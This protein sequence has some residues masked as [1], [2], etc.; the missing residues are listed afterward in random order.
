[1]DMVSVCY[2]RPV[3]CTSLCVFCVCVCVGLSQVI[4]KLPSPRM[5]S[6]WAHLDNDSGEALAVHVCVSLSLPP[7]HT[8]THSFSGQITPYTHTKTHKSWQEVLQL[9]K[10][11]SATEL[12]QISHPLVENGENEVSVFIELLTICYFYPVCPS[13]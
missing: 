4:F 11:F 5:S 3:V 1:M 6:L 13:T 10:H 7:T 12:I 8:H 9:K 2:S